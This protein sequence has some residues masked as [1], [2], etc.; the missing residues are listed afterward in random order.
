[1]AFDE[2]QLPAVVINN[3]KLISMAGNL[4]AKK[5]AEEVATQKALTDE[6][7]KLDASKI[8]YPDVN[9]WNAKYENLLSAG[10]LASKNPTDVKSQIQYKTALNEAKSWLVG[11]NYIKENFDVPN[12]KVA[13][14]SDYNDKDRADAKNKTLL[15]QE[16][17]LASEP[18]LYNKKDKKDYLLEIANAFSPTIYSQDDKYRYKNDLTRSYKEL[19]SASDLHATAN[20]E[21]ETGASALAEIAT[22]LGVDL[23][24]PA[25][26]KAAINKYVDTIWKL[27]QPNLKGDRSNLPEDNSLSVGFGGWDKKKEGLFEAR[28]ID[29]FEVSKGNPQA[30]QRLKNKLG[31]GSTVDVGNKDNLIITYQYKTKDANG[32]EE[33]KNATY[34]IP[35]NKGQ[36]AFYLAYNPLYDAVNGMGNKDITNEEMLTYLKDPKNDRW[37]KAGKKSAPAKVATKAVANPTTKTTAQV[38]AAKAAAAAKATSAKGAKK[39]KAASKGST[40]PPVFNGLNFTPPTTP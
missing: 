31:P 15:T 20:L 16:E 24:T 18:K 40:P 30:I 13:Y 23:G 21:T 36:M 9:T 4:M 38:A 6:I 22:G 12:V 5:K 37:L 28:A 27:A 39:G 26:K 33:I 34:T 19:K 8:R 25:G 7:A 11:N 14:D 32:V 29:M 35:K 3:N 2:L 17:I 10:T 1:M